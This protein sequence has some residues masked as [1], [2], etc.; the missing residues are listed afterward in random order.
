LYKSSE[1]E[2]AEFLG[3]EAKPGDIIITIGAG[4][5]FQWHK[6]ILKA[7]KK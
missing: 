6:E 2:V 5:I 7:L 4:S 1:K 3:N